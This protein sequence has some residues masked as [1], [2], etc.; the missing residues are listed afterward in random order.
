MIYPGNLTVNITSDV[1]GKY[2][3]KIGNRQKEI[4]LTANVIGN[5]T[6][7]RL[8]AK[9]Y[10]INVTYNETENYTSATNNTVK[11]NVLKAAQ[12]TTPSKQ[13]S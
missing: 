4:D 11:V 7:T 6:F 10:T 9:E 13:A 2:T 12:Q 8:S 3:I 1:S 5:I